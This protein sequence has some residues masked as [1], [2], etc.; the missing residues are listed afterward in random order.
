MARF[1]RFK[2]VV[3]GNLAKRK[4]NSSADGLKSCIE[5]RVKK[6]LK[7]ENSSSKRPQPDLYNLERKHFPFFKLM[8]NKKAWKKIPLVTELTWVVTTKPLD[9]MIKMRENGY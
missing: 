5:K 3:D 1:A 7:R 9:T 4:T 2:K 6:E 8:N